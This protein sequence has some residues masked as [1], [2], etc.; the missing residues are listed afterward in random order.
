MESSPFTCNTH[1]LADYKEKFLA[2]YKSMRFETTHRKL[3]ER[4]DSHGT[5]AVSPFGRE[6]TSVGKILAGLAKIGVHNVTA[7]DIAKMLPLDG[8]EPMLGI[9][10]DVCA[11]FQ[12]ESS[13][14]TSSLDVALTLR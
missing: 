9:M 11:Y 1:Y 6:I 7:R 2:H 8:M 3:A 4:L 5:A 14:V 13:L 10:A 12:G